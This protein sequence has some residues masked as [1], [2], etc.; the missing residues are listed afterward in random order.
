[1]HH[2]SSPLSLVVILIHPTG[3]DLATASTPRRRDAVVAQPHL[4]TT[5]IAAT[6]ITLC[7]ATTDRSHHTK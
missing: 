4:C 3:V 1:I 5:A 2:T 6:T 7:T